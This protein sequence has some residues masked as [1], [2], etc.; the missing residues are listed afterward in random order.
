MEFGAPQSLEQSRQ[1]FAEHMPAYYAHPDLAE[2]HLPDALKFYSEFMDVFSREEA[3]EYALYIFDLASE[4]R[5]LVAAQAIL[6]K[7]I[8]WCEEGLA[9]HHLPRL[10]CL[11][12]RIAIVAQ[13]FEQAG[14][15]L[16]RAM[17][18]A[19]AQQDPLNLGFCLMMACMFAHRQ[20]ELR[21]ASQ[22]AQDAVQRFNKRSIVGHG[23]KYLQYMRW[24][25]VN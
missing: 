7:V 2:Q 6:N 8:I 9:A 23:F 19:Q 16:E 20:S 5:E 25:C 3:I 18:L 13:D 10:L 11:Q 4:L 21:R 24:S 14:P 17:H 12:V 22:F 15:R 1:W